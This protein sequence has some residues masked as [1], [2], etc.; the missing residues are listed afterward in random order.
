MILQGLCMVKLA[1][2]IPVRLE[3]ATQPRTQFQGP[4]GGR[5]SYHTERS[6]KQSTLKNWT[7]QH[8]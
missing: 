1:K 6:E 4:E 2:G 8:H 3:G 7:Q 5:W